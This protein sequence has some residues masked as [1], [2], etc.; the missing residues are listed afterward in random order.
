MAKRL[1]LLT[2][3]ILL[4]NGFYI[5]QVRNDQHQYQTPTQMLSSWCLNTAPTM[6]NLVADL[7][8][9]ISMN[10]LFLKFKDALLHIT[11]SHS[12][13]ML[14]MTRSIAMDAID[15]PLNFNIADYGKQQ[16]STG[17]RPI[18]HCSDQKVLCKAHQLLCN[19]NSRWSH[20]VMFPLFV[21]ILG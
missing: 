14:I 4:W 18:I 2:R 17:L 6:M 13:Q 20:F 7:H 12:I 16:N 15:F 9:I 3:L 5:C 11:S 10:Q 8:H 19:T 21:S 1:I